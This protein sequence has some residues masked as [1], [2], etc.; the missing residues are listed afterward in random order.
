MVHEVIKHQLQQKAVQQMYKRRYETWKKIY[1]EQ[2]EI[3]EYQEA[4]SAK[5]TES[6]DEDGTGGA[7]NSLYAELYQLH[8]VTMISLRFASMKL[9]FTQFS[10][11]LWDHAYAMIFTVNTWTHST[12]GIAPTAYYVDWQEEKVS[13][14][15]PLNY[16]QLYDLHIQVFDYH[17]SHPKEVLVGEG[18]ISLSI[19]LGASLDREVPLDIPIYQVQQD[20]QN[21]IGR[22]ACDSLAS[23]YYQPAPEEVDKHE[24]LPTSHEIEHLE[25]ICIKQT[26]VHTIKTSYGDAKVVDEFPTKGLRNLICDLRGDNWQLIDQFSGNYS[27][28]TLVKQSPPELFKQSLKVC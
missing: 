5:S 11:H 8:Y 20:T 1:E 25:D 13:D 21:L 24:L 17:G 22:L 12:G 4:K 3:K 28:D 27:I 7:S 18:K 15:L 19:L 23:L 10:P 9:T 6:L 26:E 2:Q 14:E 16:L